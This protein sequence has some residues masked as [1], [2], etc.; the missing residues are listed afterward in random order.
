MGL[1]AVKDNDYENVLQ[2]LNMLSLA[3]SSCGCIPE[4]A[5][6]SNTCVLSVVC[7]VKKKAN[8]VLVN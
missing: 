6:F 5:G 3:V 8:Y 4:A 2:P 1:Y 7:R